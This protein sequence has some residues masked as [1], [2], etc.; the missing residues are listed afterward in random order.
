MIKAHELTKIFGT[1]PALDKVS[2][3]I[4]DGSV[5]G[6]IGSNGSG[7]S[8]LLRLISGIYLPDG[9]SFCID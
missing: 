2:F 4:A 3:D 8:T 9:G 6:L 5:F 1:K 7:K